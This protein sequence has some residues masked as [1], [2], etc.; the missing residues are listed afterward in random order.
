MS[1][2]HAICV[3][4]FCTFVLEFWCPWSSLPRGKADVKF[5][6]RMPWSFVLGDEPP[7][8]THEVVEAILPLSQGLCPPSGLL[9]RVAHLAHLRV[10]R[11]T[12]NRWPM[13]C[14]PSI[15]VGRRVALC[16]IKNR[17]D[18]PPSICSLPRQPH[19]ETRLRGPEAH[20]PLTCHQGPTACS[21]VRSIRLRLAACRLLPAGLRV[22][23]SSL[24]KLPSTRCQDLLRV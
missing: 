21:T 23:Q 10:V 4:S 8:L 24:R 20:R 17:G 22:G 2:W 13:A 11:T 3:Y 15:K 16:Q 1:L 18:A 6:P 14:H 9:L 19:Y 12:H 5:T 7:S